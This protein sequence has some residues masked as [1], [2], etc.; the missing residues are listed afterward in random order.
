MNALAI[1]LSLI[2]AADGDAGITL[3]EFRQNVSER[4]TLLDP[5]E[6]RVQY[7]ETRAHL[8]DL[9]K[10]FKLNGNY[11]FLNDKGRISFEFEAQRLRIDS[12]STAAVYKEQGSGAF[13]GKQL[14]YVQGTLGSDG[15]IHRRGEIKNTLQMPVNH[16]QRFLTHVGWKPVSEILGEQGTEMIGM[17]PLDVHQVILIEQ[18]TQKAAEWRTRLYFNPDHGF[19]IERMDLAWRDKPD[20]DWLTYS[21]CN[22]SDF[23]GFQKGL[24]LPHRVEEEHLQLSPNSGEMQ[25][26]WSRVSNLKW[27]FPKKVPE[28]VFE[29]DFPPDTQVRDRI[30]G[31]TFR[32]PSK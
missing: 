32:T 23:K 5:Y 7:A 6:V 16:P 22:L 30:N 12:N 9:S 26:L 15:A 31:N 14:K 18:R 27:D 21:R 24:W 28:A 10:H 19:A 2:F 13:D 4:E 1:V 17:V 8:G 25:L 29:F 20:A 11:T 3:D